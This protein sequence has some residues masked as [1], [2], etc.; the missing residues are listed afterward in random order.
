LKRVI[1]PL[2]IAVTALCAFDTASAQIER[3]RHELSGQVSFMIRSA[4]GSSSSFDALTVSA[5]YGYF[6]TNA[7]EFEPEL[8]FGKYKSSDPGFIVS[9]N[10]AYNIGGSN[11]D[12][13]TV[14]FLLAGGGVANTFIWLP[15]APY[16]SLDDTHEVINAGAG[17]KVLLTNQIA[18]RLEYRYRRFFMSRDIHHHDLFIGLSAFFGD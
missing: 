10:L 9:M 4:E 11:P 12:N 2:A 14:P 13:R 17:I 15:N 16:I 18:L 7:L 1:I 8:M 6:I 3:G 5:R